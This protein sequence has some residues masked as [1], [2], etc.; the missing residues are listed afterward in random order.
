VVGDT[1]DDGVNQKATAVAYW[2]LLM[3]DFMPK[4]D[5][6]DSPHQVQRGATYIVRSA[7]A[8]SGALVKELSQAVWSI[9]ANL[10]LARV[11]T[12]Q[13]IYDAS[14]ARTSFTLVMLG[15][16]GAMALLLG[17]AGIYSVMSY[18]VAQRTREIGIRIALGAQADRVRRMFVGHG[19]TLGGIGAA[20][21][22]AAAIAMMRLMSSLLFEISP[23]DPVTY[24]SVLAMLIAA[25]GL[26]SY[27]PAMRATSVDPIQALR[28]E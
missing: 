11:R 12:L 2:P 15:I 24:G 3:S 22:L 25:T 13:D 23:V 5:L 17:I 4:S 27:V 8:G 16:A 20:I 21:G 28:S 1:R 19:L 6:T 14:L 9:N 26:A 7:R 10:P 18:S